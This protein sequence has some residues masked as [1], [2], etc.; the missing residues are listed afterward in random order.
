M[1]LGVWMSP[2]LSDKAARVSE[3]KLYELPVIE[4]ESSAAK[5]PTLAALF[6]STISA[7]VPGL[8]R[9]KKMAKVLCTGWEQ[10][11]L[12]TRTMLLESAGHEVRQAKTQK[13]VVSQCAE[14]QFKVAVI[15][16][17][18]SDRI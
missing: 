4:E 11:L 12:D 6:R 13:E 2:E 3:C 16:Q 1:F 9:G 14:H 18:V 5:C 15:G 8:K 7:T 10:S 17:Y